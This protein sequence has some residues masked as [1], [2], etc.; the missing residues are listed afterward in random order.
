MERTKNKNEE[1]REKVCLTQKSSNFLVEA[2]M[3]WKAVGQEHQS[4]IDEVFEWIVII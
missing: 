4:P 3:L 2:E 1:S